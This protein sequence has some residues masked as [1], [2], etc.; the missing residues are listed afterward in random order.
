[1]AARFFADGHLAEVGPDSDEA[2]VIA[3]YVEL[4]KVQYQELFNRR[5]GDRR[6]GGDTSL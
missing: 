3:D 6:R 1:M 5:L 2:A 4:L